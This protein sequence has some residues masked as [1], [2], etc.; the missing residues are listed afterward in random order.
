MATMTTAGPLTHEQVESFRRD[1]FVRG[2]KVLDGGHVDELVAELHRV[3]LDDNPSTPKPVRKINMT[4]DPARPLWQIVNIWQAS[5]AYRQLISHPI[6]VEGIAQ[7][8]DASSLRI[9]HDQIQ[10]KPEESGGANPWHQDAPL[11]PIIEP[12]TEVSA[13]VALDDVDEGNGCMSM[14]PGSHL[15]GE[16]MSFVESL[17]SFTELPA[18][19]AGHPL[20]VRTCPV[21]R[22]EVHFHHALT[23]HGSAANTSGRPRRAVALHYMTGETRYVAAGDHPMK[24]LVTVSDGDILAGQAFPLV[25]ERGSVVPPPD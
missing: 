18:E 21:S 20:Q 25:Y 19:F 8:T 13:W 3:I 24:P 1:G 2:P 14:V 23:W 15:W 16:N 5:S 22:G 6:I 10:F 4:S 7:L 17:R 11:W 9:W 12:M